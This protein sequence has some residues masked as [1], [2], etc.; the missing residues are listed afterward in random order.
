MKG[1]D[2][3]SI[4]VPVCVNERIT[5]AGQLGLGVPTFT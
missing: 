2:E 3:M 5:P 1:N 4:A